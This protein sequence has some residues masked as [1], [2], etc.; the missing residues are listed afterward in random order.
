MERTDGERCGKQQTR[1]RGGRQVE[2]KARRRSRDGE[3]YFRFLCAQRARRDAPINRRRALSLL[4]P[5]SRRDVSVARVEL[6]RSPGAA[7][8]EEGGPKHLRLPIATPLR[9]FPLPR[10]DPRQNP[11]LR[12]CNSRSARRRETICTRYSR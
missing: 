6:L 10:R 12:P 3:E 4:T 7:D 11:R 2:M 8:A 9:A 5:P 1:T